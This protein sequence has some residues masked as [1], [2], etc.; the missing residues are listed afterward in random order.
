MD[1]DF[2]TD[3]G[4]GEPIDSNKVIT[5]GLLDSV[6]HDCGLAARRRALDPRPERWFD[7]I[8]EKL[9]AQTYERFV[10]RIARKW[11]IPPKILKGEPRGELDGD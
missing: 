10:Q 3:S 2:Y 11:K 4:L 6:G 8:L 5:K 1:K 7:F 9:G